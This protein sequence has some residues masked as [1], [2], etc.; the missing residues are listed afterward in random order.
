MKRV[1]PLHNPMIEQ[2][3]RIKAQHPVV[4]IIY[5]MGDFYEPFCDDAERASRLLG[6]EKQTFAR[7][8]M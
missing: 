5:R 3:L 8:A 1:L 7:L 6:L 2:Y 4:L